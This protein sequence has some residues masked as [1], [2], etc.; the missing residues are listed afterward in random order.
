MTHFTTGDFR[1]L[2]HQ[3]YK[4]FTKYPLRENFS[5]Y[6]AMFLSNYYFV[7]DFW[8]TEVSAIYFAYFIWY[9]LVAS[10]NFKLRKFSLILRFVKYMFF[11]STT[12]CSTFFFFT[13]ISLVHLECSSL[14][15]VSLVRNLFLSW[16]ITLFWTKWA[17]LLIHE[18]ENGNLVNGDKS[19]WDRMPP[20]CFS[21]HFFLHASFFFSLSLGS[22]DQPFI[23]SQLCH[24][25]VNLSPIKYY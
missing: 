23:F 16:V 22:G 17:H 9:S 14:S 18:S 12:F 7:W 24:L 15:N 20:G 11:L 2:L 19:N 3:F 4:H 8:Q 21:H 1:A 5:K 10:S 25:K 6:C 13:F